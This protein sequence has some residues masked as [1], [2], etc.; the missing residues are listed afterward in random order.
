MV[1]LCDSHVPSTDVLMICNIPHCGNRSDFNGDGNIC[2]RCSAYYCSAHFVD[3]IHTE[4][5]YCDDCRYWFCNECDVTTEQYDSTVL[6]E[7]CYENRGY[8]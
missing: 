2:N 6:C 7:P 3:G 8:G 1:P 4:G 5:M